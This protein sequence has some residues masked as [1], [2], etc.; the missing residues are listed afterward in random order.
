MVGTCIIM[1]FV[2]GARISHFM[3]FGFRIAGFVG[4][5]LSAPY[6]MKR[7]TSFLD[8]WQTLL[9]GFSNYSI[10]VCDWARW[11]FWTRSRSEQ[12]KI[13]LLPNLKQILFLLL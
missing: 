8:P 7:I 6:R 10:F 4:L 11:F 5:I 12:A 3:G 2:S 1:V 13:L 9:L